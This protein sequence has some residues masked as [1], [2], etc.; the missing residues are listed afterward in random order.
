MATIHTFTGNEV[1]ATE[2]PQYLNQNF[3]GMNSELTALS[4]DAITSING[5]KATNNNFNVTEFVSYWQPN[6]VVAL[7]EI[8]FLGGR[9]NNGT[10]L[11][12]TKTGTTGS[13]QPSEEGVDN[14]TSWKF[15]RLSDLLIKS[16][17]YN[18]SDHLVLPDGSEFWIG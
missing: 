1:I 7:G 6:E 2:V 18:S 16:E 13:I 9:E 10:I 12:C 11:E 15:K 14:T 4:T 17:I 5:K 3:S 8:R